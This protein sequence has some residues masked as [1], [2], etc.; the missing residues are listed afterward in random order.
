MADGLS[1]FHLTHLEIYPQS[2]YA[3]YAGYAGYAANYLLFGSGGRAG[4][5]VLW[6]KPLR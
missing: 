2:R 4:V 3:G 1:R 5:L 6:P